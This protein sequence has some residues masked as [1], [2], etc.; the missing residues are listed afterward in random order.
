MMSHF[1]IRDNDGLKMQVIPDLHR[2][3]MMIE[4]AAR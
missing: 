3:Q 2:A 1:N 4:A